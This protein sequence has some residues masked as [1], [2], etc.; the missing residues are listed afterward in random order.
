MFA[1]RQPYH[2][3]SNFKFSNNL[4]GKFYNNHRFLNS[5]SY[6]EAEIKL[7]TSG[8][9]SEQNKIKSQKKMSGQ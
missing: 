3:P 5:C 9:D 6:L 7:S 4:T 1:V 8:S 2:Q